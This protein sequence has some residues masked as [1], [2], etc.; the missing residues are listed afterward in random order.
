[1]HN[2]NVMYDT[3]R[4]QII[5]SVSNLDTRFPKK[6]AP[7]IRVRLFHITNLNSLELYGSRDD[8]EVIIRSNHMQIIENVETNQ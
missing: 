3:I 1:M 5:C 2:A 8:E 7:K 4:L 6:E